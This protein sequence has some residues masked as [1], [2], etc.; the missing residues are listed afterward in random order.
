MPY[1][2]IHDGTGTVI[3]FFEA[4]ERTRTYTKFTLI[5][6]PTEA[7]CMAELEKLGAKE[8][9]VDSVKRRIIAEAPT[10]TKDTE[11]VKLPPEKW[12]ILEDGS[13]KVA[14]EIKPVEIVKEPVELTKA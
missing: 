5:E 2:L 4:G 10:L 3:E 6:K 8:M 9:Y 1:R 11:A 7:E 14:Y 13:V 12:T